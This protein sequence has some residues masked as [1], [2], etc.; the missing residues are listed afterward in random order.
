MGQPSTRETCEELSGEGQ[1]F[2]ISVLGQLVGQGSDP[3]TELG[4]GVWWI[5]SGK[6]I[7]HTH[8]EC[9]G[10]LFNDVDGARCTACLQTTNVS[11]AD[12]RCCCEIELRHALRQPCFPKA[13]GEPLN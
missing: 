5:G 2:P 13:T 11:H 3:F 9:L 10:E 8:G 12:A 1:R 4:G 7:G 6:E